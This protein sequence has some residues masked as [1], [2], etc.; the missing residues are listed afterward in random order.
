MV[1]D[2]SKKMV[3]RTAHPLETTWDP[4]VP[5]QGEKCLRKESLGLSFSPSDSWPGTL[6]LKFCTETVFIIKSNHGKLFSTDGKA[7]RQ[8]PS[9]GLYSSCVISTVHFLY[10]SHHSTS[11]PTPGTLRNRE[12]VMRHYQLSFVHGYGAA[13]PLPSSSLCGAESK[14]NR[15]VTLHGGLASPSSLHLTDAE[16]LPMSAPPDALQSRQKYPPG[17]KGDILKCEPQICNSI[18]LAQ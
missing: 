8:V 14:T 12:V 10:L 15:I 3:R 7:R 6:V 16:T 18:E 13:S 4:L 9:T 2:P 1:Q 17:L 11:H 5:S